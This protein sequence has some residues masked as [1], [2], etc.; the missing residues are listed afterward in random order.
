MVQ[1]TQPI[2]GRPVGATGEETRQRVLDATM[3][4]VAEVGY[5]KATIREIARMADMTSGSLYHYFPNKTELI[6]ATFDEVAAMSIP[7]VVAAGERET[8]FRGRLMA[9]LDECDQMMREYPLIAAFDRAIRV[10]AARDLAENRETLFSTL[11]TIL[12]DIIEQA[13]REKALRKGVKVDAAASAIFIVLSGLTDY[14]ATSSPKD[15]HAT[16]DALKKLVAG[17]LFT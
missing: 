5:S 15:Y 14:G 12:V 3:R 7:R 10:G 11:R 8:D 9:V 17:T 1:A 13:R 2:L 16:V 6:K 4:C